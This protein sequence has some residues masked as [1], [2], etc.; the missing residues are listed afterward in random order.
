MGERAIAEI[1]ARL[2]Q[3]CGV[4]ELAGI[5]GT[6]YAVSSPSTSSGQ[7]GSGVPENAVRLPSLSRQQSD[8]SAV[9]EAEKLYQK[10]ANPDGLPV[11]QDEEPG[12]IVAMPPAEPLSGEEL[13]SLYELPFSRRWHTKYDNAGGVAAIEPVRFSITTHRGCFG[14]CSFCSLYF[15]QGK[16]ICSRSTDSI[17]AEAQRLRVRKD[18]NGTISDI[19]GPTANMYGMSCGREESCGRVSCLFPS[20]CKYLKADARQL[21]SLMEGI[22][23]WKGGR[24]KGVNVYVASGVRHDLAMLSGGY[25][26]ILV[27]HFVSGQLKVA[28]E[29]Y[30]P[31]VLELMGKPQIEVFEEFEAR[32]KEISRKAGKEQYLVPYFVSSHPGCTVEDAF[33]L[34]EY[35][36]K[37]GWSP[38][39]VQ[40][41]VPVPLTMSAAMYV[42]G[43]DAKGKKIYVAKGRKEKRLQA[44][45]LQYNEPANI[46]I[47]TEF[48]RTTGRTEFLGKMRRR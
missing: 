8:S 26:E 20:P 6:V 46:K 17:L 47:V 37:R 27:R 25:M 16:Q 2:A 19:G 24:G 40:D 7:G 22:L 29:H 10:Q 21:I 39:Q 31:R 12:T 48:L 42:S 15:H 28:P 45:L 4:G 36:A 18:F 1:T 11:V 14:G 33:A 13:D 34:T 35:L 41:F 38:Q 23:R 43:V 30:C 5:A 32:F 9:M 3:G 44:A